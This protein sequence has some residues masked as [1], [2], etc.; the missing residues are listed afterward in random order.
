MKIITQKTRSV[1][2]GDTY[3]TMKYFE[4]LVFN[5]DRNDTGVVVKGN[6]A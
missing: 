1:V 6:L 5:A 2:Y 4:L 3:K